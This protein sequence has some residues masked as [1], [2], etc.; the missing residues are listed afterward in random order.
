[1][2]PPYKRMMPHGTFFSMSFQVML[3]VINK[4]ITAEIRALKNNTRGV[5][6]TLF[7][8]LVSLMMSGLERIAVMA[9]GGRRSIQ[10]RLSR[11][12]VDHQQRHAAMI[13]SS[14]IDSNNTTLHSGKSRNSI[15]FMR[16]KYKKLIP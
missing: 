12:C 13:G 15:R 4:M 1:M 9:N 2:A 5:N 3:P 11:L 6:F 8:T 7:L 14:P 10:W 16:K